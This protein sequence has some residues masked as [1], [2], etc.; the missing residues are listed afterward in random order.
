MGIPPVPKPLSFERSPSYPPFVLNRN[1]ADTC[2][3]QIVAK[4]LA[5]SGFDGKDR[6]GVIVEGIR[7]HSKYQSVLFSCLSRT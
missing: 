5:H 4:M 3:R 6:A 2:M 1:V 7:N